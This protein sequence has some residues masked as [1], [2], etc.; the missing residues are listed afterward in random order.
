MAQRNN[1]SML[2]AS[3]LLND[4]G[5][6]TLFEI[7]RDENVFLE[8]KVVPYQSYIREGYFKVILTH[9]K[10]H[11]EFIGLPMTL[12]TPKGLIWLRGRLDKYYTNNGSVECVEV[13]K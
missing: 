3:K 10:V 1:V 4:C 13:V 2:I 8:G 5:R 11:G 9:K 6:N 12:I 7:L